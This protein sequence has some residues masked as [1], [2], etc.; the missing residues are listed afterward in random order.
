MIRLVHFLGFVPRYS[1][2][3]VVAEVVAGIYRRTCALELTYLTSKIRSAATDGKAAC[4]MLG[5]DLARSFHSVV[6]DIRDA[7]YMGEVPDT[8]EVPLA[9]GK[10]GLN[11]LLG[12]SAVLEVEPIGSDPNDVNNWRQVHR[13]RLVRIVQDGKVLV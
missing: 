9:D 4:K 13:V 5:E 8:Q 1:Q 12:H 2:R 7:M 6:A 3:Q 10:M 11:Y